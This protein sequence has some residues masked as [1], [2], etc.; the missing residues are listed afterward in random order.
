MFRK[1][2]K[3]TLL[4]VLAVFIASGMVMAEEKI[5]Y[6]YN[7]S[8]YIAEDTLANFTKETGIKVVYDV[9]DG[10]EVLETKLLAGRTGF[11]IVVPSNSFLA[12]QIK[13]GVFQ[14]MDR[15]KLTNFD[16]L[17]KSLLK[18][19]ETNDPGNQYAVPYLWGTTGLGMNID[20][21]QA[22]LGKDVP[23]NTWELVFNPEYIS[24]LKSCG[25]SFLDAPS[26]IPASALL[27]LG[28]N[29]N[30]LNPSDYSDHAEPLLMKIREYVTYF[31]SSKYI[32]DLANGDICL[33]IGWSGD[34]VQA[35]TRA[36][37]AG[38]G[39]N[40]KYV[41]PKEGAGLWFDMLAIPAD[42]KN[43]ENAHI[44]INYLLRPDVIA[45]ITNYVWYA[46]PNSASTSLVNEEITSDTSIY[47]DA[48]TKKNLFT[49]DVMPPKID[50]IQN[51]LMT[52]MR[53]GQ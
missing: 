42:A 12:R 18:T 19:L 36:E 22:A 31:H 9:F 16:N 49:F 4:S 51:R 20:K 10:N 38:N 15:S 21:V 8:D 7:W 5:V 45:E 17:D 25:V 1:L 3:K 13:A 24:K 48:E 33:A 47:P 34:V 32:N 14:K 29:P 53:T 39:V 41:I 11:D 27:Y 40:V 43:V 35:A 26:E 6:V 28:L 2:M 46:N 30:S 50:R 52:R 37:E 44:F 23:L